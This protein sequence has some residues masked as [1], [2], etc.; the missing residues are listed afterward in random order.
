MATAVTTEIL[1]LLDANFH[2][3]AKLREQ[4]TDKVA[5]LTAEK[6]ELTDKVTTLTDKWAT[7]R[8][9]LLA[10]IAALS[11][12]IGSE[13]VKQL[14]VDNDR[15]NEEVKQLKVD[16]DKKNEEVKQLQEQ[17]I[18]VKSTVQK[19]TNKIAKSIG[20]NNYS[21]PQN[22]FPNIETKAIKKR[23]ITGV[24]A[25]IQ[26]KEDAEVYKQQYDKLANINRERTKEITERLIEKQDK[27][28]EECSTSSSSSVTQRIDR[29]KL[30]WSN[31]RKANW[32]KLR[33]KREISESKTMSKNLT[34]TIEP[35]VSNNLT[36]TIEP[37]T[38]TTSSQNPT[39]I[40]NDGPSQLFSF[41]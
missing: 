30:P 27:K 34:T 31:E 21:L 41:P 33:H 12:P 17:L 16:N 13:E 20:I 14:K 3:D 35:T 25:A 1:K 39:V 36:T 8:S 28:N 5:T 9:T 26:L 10:K 29:R 11:L 37:I 23:K 32:L 19:I 15:K 4:L 6:D 7:E 18:S 40:F 2:N 38:S 24:L 22:L